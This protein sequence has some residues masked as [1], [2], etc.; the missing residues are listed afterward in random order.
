MLGPGLLVVG[1]GSANSLAASGNNVFYADSGRGVYAIDRITGTNTRL[2]LK[3]SPYEFPDEVAAD[4]FEVYWTDLN[5][6]R[7][8]GLPIL[9]PSAAPT[10]LSNPPQPNGLRLYL[11]RLYWASN[12]GVIGWTLPDGGAEQRY[13]VGGTPS[14]LDVEGDLVYFTDA[15]GPSGPFH[16]IRK[17]DMRNGQ[18]STIADHQGNLGRIIVHQGYVY[19][20]TDEGPDGGTLS[21]TVTDGGAAIEVVARVPLPVVA[22]AKDGT[23]TIFFGTFQNSPEQA[24]DAGI[25]K[26]SISV[27]STQQVAAG[28]QY[29]ID[30]LP[31]PE[32]LFWAEQTRRIV[33]LSPKP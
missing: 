31:L 20:G 30:V 14:E 22:L 12:A 27:G 28:L 16:S 21:R 6:N 11:G 18:V 8:I 10:T 13:P 3:I 29:P 5:T 19:W 1:S 2:Y 15:S 25:Y 32:A 17:L 24:F 33:R 4:E 23:D 7:V 26:F 9:D